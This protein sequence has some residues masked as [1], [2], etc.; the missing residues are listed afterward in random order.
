[1]RIKTAHIFLFA[2]L[3]MLLTSCTSKLFSSKYYFEHAGSVDSL[4][5]TYEQIYPQQPFTIAF[6]DKHLNT[7]IIEIITDTL[8]YRYE[9]ETGEKRFG[10]TLSKFGMN[11]LAVETL[12]QQMRSIR[13]TWI[14]NFD[15]Y[16][17]DKK[18]SLIFI[19]I[20]PVAFRI[21]FSYQKY[22]ILTYF[23]QPQYFDKDGR[24]LDKK[25]IRRLRK[26][27]G[28]VFR[29]IN[30]KVCYTISGNFR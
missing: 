20:K 7:F 23:S 9:F 21:P 26:I 29:R 22:Y 27:N 25:N 1:M 17:D 4:K 18:N 2:G 3:L 12:V 6:T 24:L 28:E 30:D 5:N 19:S 16:V 10:D 11:S 15:Y 8:S 13:C 14:N